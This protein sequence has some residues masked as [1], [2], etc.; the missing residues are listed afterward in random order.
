ME[1][2]QYEVFPKN[3]LEIIPGWCKGCSLC[4]NACPKGILSLDIRG[5][6]QVDSSG[7]CTGCGTCESTCPDYAI[8]VMVS[9][10]E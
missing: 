9:K 8:A 4:V 3:Q 2:A 5:K 1:R 6:V 10:N 7:R